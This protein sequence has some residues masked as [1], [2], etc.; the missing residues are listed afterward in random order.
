M[1]QRLATFAILLQAGTSLAQ[2]PNLSHAIPSAAVPGKTIEV[3]FFGENLAGATALWTSFPAKTSLVRA[4]DDQAVWRITLPADVEPGIGAVRLATTNGVSSLELFMVDD[5][6]SVVESATNRS[7]G[8]AQELKPP[9]AVD[10]A[11]E[12]LGFDY[13]K[14]SAKKGQRIAMEVVAQRLGSRL[15]SVLRLFDAKGREMAWCDDEPGLGADARFAHRFAASGEYT[16]EVRDMNYQ[17]GARYRYR[18]RLGDFPLASLPFPS[19]A[20]AGVKTKFTVLGRD[21]AG[22]KPVALTPSTSSK[23]VLLGVKFPGGKSSGFVSARTGALPELIE[24]EPNDASGDATKISIPTAINGR[25]AK[26]N[27]HDF[28]EFTAEKEQRLAF[29][30]R[31][32]SLG[33]PCDL[34]MQLQRADGS[35]LAETKV[36]GADEGSLTNTFKE[37]GAYRLLVEELNGTGGPDLAYRIEIAPLLPGFALSVDTDKVQAASRGVFEIKVAATRRDYDGPIRLSLDGAGEGFTLE[38][39]VI[40]E[41]KT[42]TTLKVKLPPR[43]QPG[44]LAH[45]SITGQAAIGGRD[46]NATASTLSALRKLFPNTPHPPAELDGLIGL[47]IKA[48]AEGGK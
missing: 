24:A 42:E 39:G 26:A 38:N 3:T 2:T 44:Q 46:V 23:R 7:P 9:V 17:G 48:A 22:V 25:F 18:L 37:A 32:R 4:A 6:P 33:S 45:F 47:G 14:F 12:E 31:T 11:S 27:D 1:N 34:F 43:F 16:L 15:D 35:K 29:H 10:G 30:G 36:T 21:T 13:F 20:M 19:G 5:V 28:Y 8:T 41:K 40:A